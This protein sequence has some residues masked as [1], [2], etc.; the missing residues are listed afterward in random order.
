MTGF[1]AAAGRRPN[2]LGYDTAK[3]KCLAIELAFNE[4]SNDG[5]DAISKF[6]GSGRI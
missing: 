6:S 3:S 2:N 1:A 5:I 4:V